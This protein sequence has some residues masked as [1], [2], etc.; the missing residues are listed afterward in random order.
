V[1]LHRP[2]ADDQLGRDL[3]VRHPGGDEVGHLDLPQ[4]QRR[5]RA[6]ARR[7]DPE[8][9]QLALRLGAVAGSSDLRKL[10][11]RAREGGDRLVPA[12]GLGE[13][14]AHQDRGPAG[15]DR[16]PLAAEQGLG[17]G[18][19]HRRPLRLAAGQQHARPP[20]PHLGQPPRELEAPHQL[21]SAREPGLGLVDV[22]Q[23]ELGPAEQLEPVAAEARLDHLEVLAARA[24]QDLGPPAPRVAALDQRR[25]EEA[26]RQ[27]AERRAGGALQRLA[28]QLAARHRGVQLPEEHADPGAVRERPDEQLV[29]VQQRRGVHRGL[30]ARRRRGQLAQPQ[31]GHRERDEH[32]HEPE[33]LAGL[34]RDGDAAPQRRGRLLV[35]LQPE[36]RLADEE[37]GLD[38][39]RELLVGEGL[40][41]RGGL[42][43]H[44]LARG[45]VRPVVLGERQQRPG[46]RLE[47]AL[48]ERAG[49]VERP[50][51][52]VGQRVPVASI[53]A[54]EGELQLER[55]RRRRPLVPE[56]GQGA[57]EHVARGPRVAAH[58]LDAGHEAGDASAHQ[59]LLLGHEVEGVDQDWARLV[60]AAR[61]GVRHGERHQ[62]AEPAIGLALGQQS[63]G[64]GEPLGGRR[65][66][67]AGVLA[68]GR[69]EQVH[70]LGVAGRGRALDVVCAR[71]Q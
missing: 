55:A 37:H 41:E 7:R 28:G 36:A 8:P 45:G 44:P 53:P 34:A 51:G 47:A 70:G 63:Q 21:L 62:Q 10:F 5:G 60:D 50:G 30:H 66:G 18:R 48:A 17:L 58:V 29:V 43:Q 59:L 13:R 46:L 32:R 9:R 27:P 12:A 15:V 56:A 64:G 14:P 19:L 69:L 22:A 42:R 4:R 31:L 65:G 61:R 52:V 23:A 2:G 26:V 49:V 68:P 3:A 16:L 39:A 24:D 57:R 6:A 11:T 20:A 67:A 33:L 38:R 71:G 35:A 40:D 1:P 25:A 54:V